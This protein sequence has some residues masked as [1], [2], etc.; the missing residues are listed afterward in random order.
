MAWSLSCE[1]FFYATLPFIA[2][3]LLRATPFT[4]FAV[5]GAALAGLFLLAD[6]LAA[7]APGW[8]PYIVLW[9]PPY[10]FGEFLLGVCLAVALRRGWL[11]TQRVILAAAASM[12]GY[13]AVTVANTETNVSNLLMLLPFVML[14]VA[15]AQ[16]DLAGGV[17]RRW[18]L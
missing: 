11:P 6:L 7:G 12:L 18:L 14:I 9:F 15:S 5:S 17:S 8:Q 10:R 16:H 3:R 1:V 2:P 13:V 4:V